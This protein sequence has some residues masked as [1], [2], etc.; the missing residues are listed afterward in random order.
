MMT[1]YR[2][3]AAR[4]L[5]LLAPL[6]L[7]LATLEPAGARSQVKGKFERLLPETDE[8]LYRLEVFG[9]T[10]FSC[11]TDGTFVRSVD[12]GET[13]EPKQI[14]AGIS[15]TVMDF[16]DEKTGFL[17]G[18]EKTKNVLFR[19]HDGG[20]R[21]TELGLD[22]SFPVRGLAFQ[23]A[24]RGWLITGSTR[25]RDGSWLRTTDG[26]RTFKTPDSVAYGI[27][28]R[29]LLGIT[30]VGTDRLYVVGS[31]VEVALVGDAARSLLYQKRRGSVL[32]STDSGR[33]WDVLDAGNAGTTR[34]WGVDF[35]DENTGWVVGD[36]GFAARTTDGGDTWNICDTGTEEELRAVDVVNAEVTF[37][38]GKKGTALATSDG[39]KTFAE[40]VTGTGQDLRD[41]SFSGESKG[42]VVGKT[43][44][45]LKFV[46]QY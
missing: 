30:S 28:G 2:F 21:F 19:T 26:G 23:D 37:L 24:N 15:F 31:H 17:A 46:R 36:N 10:A 11:G 33:T 7:L 39:G 34:L 1:K 32:R 38:V 14:R 8:S 16:V 12:G 40:L 25:D 45:V 6:L 22:L 4:L 43:G 3:L 35:L 13:W 44:T 41:C 42:I 27:P 20:E 18:R 9:K 29:I 5:L